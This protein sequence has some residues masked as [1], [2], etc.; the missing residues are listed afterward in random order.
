MTFKP[1]TDLDLSHATL[2]HLHS[3]KQKLL[4]IRS[5]FVALGWVLDNLQSSVDSHEAR[6]KEVLLVAQN[7][8]SECSAH[9]ENVRHLLDVAERLRI[10][11]SDALDLKN[12]DVSA[13]Q[14]QQLFDL[15]KASSRD[16][17]SI[18]IITVL[19]LLYLPFSFVA[20]STLWHL[21]RAYSLHE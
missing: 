5:I 18:R 13:Q 3:V 19:T 6:S 9:A 15:A 21:T 20:V 8:R 11:T 12:Q 1:N 16:S 14:T 4:P 10:Q 2:Q 17:L 7:L